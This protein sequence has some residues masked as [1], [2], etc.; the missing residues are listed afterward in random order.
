MKLDN[1]QQQKALE[2]VQLY[3]SDAVLNSSRMTPV[4]MQRAIT[5]SS[6]VSKEKLDMVEEYRSQI[7]KAR[8]NED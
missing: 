3:N 2:L 4:E 8:M 1:A 6:G 5:L 7:E